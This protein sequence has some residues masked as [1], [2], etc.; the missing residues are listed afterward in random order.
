MLAIG[1]GGGIIDVNASTPSRAIRT[2]RLKGHRSWVDSVAWMP[3][4]ERLVSGSGDK[5]VRVWNI[6]KKK[7]IAILE[8]HTEKV[9]S[10][11]V[12]SDG[13]LIA[14]KAADGTIRLWDTRSWK[15]VTQLAESPGHD[16]WPPGIAFHPHLPILATT[17][18]TQGVC[19]WD[20]NVDVLLASPAAEEGVKY[21]AAK[22]ALVGDSGVGKSTLGW[23]LAHRVYKDHPSTHGQQFWVVDPLRMKRPDG[24]ECEAVLWDFAGQPD[25]RIVHALFMDDIDMALVTFDATKGLEGAQYWLE[26]L[27]RGDERRPSILVAARADRGAPTET[28]SALDEFCAAHAVSGGWVVT[29]ARTGL[30]IEELVERVRT[31][32]DWAGM[33][34]TVTTETFKLIKEHVLALKETHILV[35]PETLEQQLR[36]RSV[37][38]H[39]STAEMMTA[40]KHLATHGYVAPLRGSNGQEVILLAPE[41]LIGMASSLVLEARRNE[42]GLGALSERRVL[43]GEFDW[44]DLAA[45]G[46]DDRKLLLDAALAL[47]LKHNLCFRQTVGAETLLV[48]P[49]L[50]NQKRPVLANGN[51]VEYMTYMIT[52]AV[53]NVYASLVVQLGYTGTFARVNQW[54]NQAEYETATG[55]VCGFRQAE[56]AE[57]QIE[58][59]LYH[60]RDGA[61]A[62]I[63]FQELVEMFLRTRDVTVRGFPTVVCAH[64]GTLQT[65]AAVIKRVFANK[66]QMRCEECGEP[67]ALTTV[68]DDAVATV[69]FR[70]TRQ[71]GDLAKRRTNFEAAIVRIKALAR[72]R[73]RQPP[74]CFVSYAWETEDDHQH[75][76]WVAQLAEDLEN[77]GVKIVLDQKD[78]A[79]YGLSVARFAARITAVDFVAIV[80]TPSYLRKYENRDGHVVA[81]EM[82][83]VDLRLT[84]TEDQKRTV[85]P[86]LRAGDESSSLPPFVRGRTRGDFRQDRDYFRVL[87]GLVATLYDIPPGAA[88]IADVKETLG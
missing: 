75:E 68:A 35:T 40:V 63:L 31:S 32:I 24:T 9:R 85:I 26:Q 62:R 28:N 72:D 83:L 87:F 39:F 79:L 57:G 60:T 17:G 12:S 47:F 41:L 22:I 30:G 21:V 15:M 78:N 8:G 88:E 4:G 37:N 20:V 55:D 13:R 64:C 19:L 10:V 66:T 51:V 73:N 50:I 71:E 80:G 16:Y 38:L 69:R 23:R 81:A 84:G 29:S 7:Q 42:K 58:L 11:S 34:A 43:G 56:E 25:Y 44:R 18:D 77:A 53:E 27:S 76:R 45:V 36:Q 5:S 54:Q 52:G 48:F 49:S 65:R 67:V 59:V 2:V 70:Q 86:L 3:D 46:P 61:R 33:P 6:E 14:S 82:D 1:T 74:S